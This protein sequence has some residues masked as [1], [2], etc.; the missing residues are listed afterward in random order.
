MANSDTF[1]TFVLESLVGIGAL[2]AKRMF[3]GHGVFV[4]DRM[5]ALIA[6]DVLYL[7]AD[8]HNRS[9]FEDRDM[10][11]FKPYAHRSTIMPYHRVP[12]SL[13]DDAET[14]EALAVTAADAAR[15]APAA[16]KRRG[17]RR[18]AGGSRS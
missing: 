18:A 15:R 16:P 8:E 14:L 7:R 2:R 9:V 4:D 6:D 12:D 11:A 5:F 1:V 17:R 3:G 13:F 10:A